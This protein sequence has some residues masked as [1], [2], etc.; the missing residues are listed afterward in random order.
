MFS[1]PQNFVPGGKISVQ[2]IL[3]NKNK[4]WSPWIYEQSNYLKHNEQS[5]YGS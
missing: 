3:I 1:K 2:K 5:N 4:P